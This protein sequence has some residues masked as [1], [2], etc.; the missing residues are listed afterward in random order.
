MTADNKVAVV[1]EI[2]GRAIGCR[3]TRACTQLSMSKCA[4]NVITFES[5]PVFS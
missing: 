3:P 5:H 4:A 2:L 1:L